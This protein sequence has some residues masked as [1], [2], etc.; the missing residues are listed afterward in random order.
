MSSF[1]V[2]VQ[3]A[4]HRVRDYEVIVVREP[5]GNFYVTDETSPPSVDDV[6]VARVPA[7]SDSLEMVRS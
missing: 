2:A 3:T 6:V 7:G 4:T 5:E 1:Y